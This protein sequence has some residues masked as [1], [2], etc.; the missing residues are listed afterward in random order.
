M[1]GDISIRIETAFSAI[2]RDIWARLGG[3]ARGQAGHVYNPFIS[4]AYLSALEESGS[5]TAKTGW[6]GQHLLIEDDEG[7]L[8]GALPCYLKNH[9]QGEYVFDHGW[10]DALERAGGQYYPKLQ[11]SVPFTPA[12]GPRLLS[13]LHVDPTATRMALTAGLQELTR[14][15]GASSAHVTFMPESEL[16]TLEAARFLH[17][18]DQQFHFTNAGYGTHDDFLETLASR[19]RKALKK[20][21]R[22]ALE[23][24]ISIDWLTG[25]D[26]TEAVW[27]QFFAFYMDTG[28]RKWGR[29]YLTRTFFSLIGERMPEDILLVM[30]KREGRYIAG[31]INFIGEDA[32][33]GRHW[34][35]IEDHPFLHFEVC[36]HQ[37]IEFAIEKKLARVE[38][39]AQG[40]HKLARGYLPVTTHS[41]HHIAHP[42]L[43]RAVEAYLERERLDVE[44]M[45]AM[46]SEHGPFRKGERQLRE[47]EEIE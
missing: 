20:E 40:E 47:G 30:A 33:Y 8:I 3:A 41:M 24:G 43:R 16:P 13:A 46:L 28:S 38:A 31:A 12:T 22:A 4:H 34:G 9:S 29:P 21:R 10:A 26:L 35:C 7:G 32:L 14:R 17:R 6:L 39:G 23:N 18:T 1:S 2:G 36:Y 27:D 42:G 44:A 25:S 45:G 11:C 37:A 15:L 5:A 19:K